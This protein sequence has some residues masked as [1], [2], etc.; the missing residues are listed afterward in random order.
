MWTDDSCQMMCVAE[1]L[2]R[3]RLVNGCQLHWA[4]YDWWN[5]GF[6]TAQSK[7]LYKLQTELCNGA[8]GSFGLG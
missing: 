5:H 7:A 1:V 2:A 8:P 4:I 6:C 3:Y